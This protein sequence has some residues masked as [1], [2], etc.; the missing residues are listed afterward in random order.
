MKKK[1]IILIIALNVSVMSFAQSGLNLGASIGFPYQNFDGYDYSFAFSADI[2]Y[3][4]EV[5]TAFDI[6]LATGYGQAFG[7]DYYRG[8]QTFEI[9]NSPIYQ[10]GEIMLYFGYLLF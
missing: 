4:F 3:L 1:L 10:I 9:S 5:S 8:F 7:E 2:N 6:G